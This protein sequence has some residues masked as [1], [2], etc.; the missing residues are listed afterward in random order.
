MAKSKKDRDAKRRQKA[1]KRTAKRK[2]ELRAARAGSDLSQ[3]ASWPFDAVMVN[4]A[5]QHPQSLVQLIVSRRRPDGFLTAAVLLVDL[6]CWGVK[7]CIWRPR[8]T[9]DGL[10]ALIEGVRAQQD[11]V[12]CSPELAAKIVREAARYGTDLGL[13]QHPA[14]G[15]CLALLQGVDPDACDVEIPLGGEDGKPLYIAG[16]RDDARAILT[17]LRERLGEG[18]FQYM[19]P[20]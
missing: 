19:A 1:A 4:A 14:L 10:G 3:A 8:I 16:P 9:A 2:Q 11:V 5:W 18:G 13:P 12:G 6:Q 15:K 20:M 7:N 17:H